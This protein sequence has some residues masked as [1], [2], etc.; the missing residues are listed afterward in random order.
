M[1]HK[2]V[3]LTVWTLHV[4]FSCCGSGSH[5]C[6]PTDDGVREGKWGRKSGERGEVNS[7]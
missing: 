7:L 2:S 4:G 6:E 5:Q 3:C 1:F